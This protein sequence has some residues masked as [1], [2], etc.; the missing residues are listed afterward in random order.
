MGVL[1]SRMRGG[2]GAART[3]RS[4]ARRRRG[5]AGPSAEREADPVDKRVRPEQVV[6]RDADDAPSC[7]LKSL[8]SLDVVAERPQVNSMNVPLVLDRDLLLR[9]REVGRSHEV[10]VV[11]HLIADKRLWQASG[12]DEQAEFCFGRRRGERSDQAERLSNPARTSTSGVR[13]DDVLEVGHG[14]ERSLLAHETVPEDDQLGLRQGR[15][16]LCPG[17]DSMSDAETADGHHPRHR[18][19]LMAYNPTHPRCAARSHRPNVQHRLAF[20]ARGQG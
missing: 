7:I 19:E 9:I 4:E 6:G 1:V 14:R 12:E 8:S 15:R 16:E 11:M 3:L 17:V 5:L 20:D 10:A 18:V 2:V 13:C